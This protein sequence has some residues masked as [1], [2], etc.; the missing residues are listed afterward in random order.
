MLTAWSMNFS[1]RERAKHIG[2]WV[3]TT[4]TD[5]SI[6]DLTCIRPFCARSTF[7]DGVFVVIVSVLL[8]NFLIT[9]LVD[10]YD[11]VKAEAAIRW[12]FIQAQG[13]HDIEMRS[14]PMNSHRMMNLI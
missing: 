6:L 2:K 1:T 8:M 13:L 9:L 10:K 3:A 12:C 11:E 14:R 4:L 7:I 5:P